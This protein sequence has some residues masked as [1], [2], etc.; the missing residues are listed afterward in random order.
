MLGETFYID[1]NDNDLHL[2][3]KRKEVSMKVRGPQGIAAVQVECNGKAL[4]PN[5]HSQSGGEKKRILHATYPYLTTL[6]P[7][8]SRSSL[9]CNSL[10]RLDRLFWFF[11]CLFIYPP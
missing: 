6:S 8:D 4:S 5:E 3:S 9:P 1:I 11:V 10:P 2:L 7:H